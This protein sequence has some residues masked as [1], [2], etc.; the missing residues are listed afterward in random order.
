[1]KSILYDRWGGP[2]VLR[3]G[4]VAEP[5]AGP[6]ELVVRVR[7][8][9]L[10]PLD[11]K[12]RT[13]KM[14]LL[15]G[16]KFPKRTGFDF[17]GIVESCGSRVTGT[18]PGDEVFG[19]TNPF[20][21]D[22]GTFAERCVVRAALAAPKPAGLSFAEAATLPCAGLSALQS[23]QHCRVGPG[24]HV[25]LIGAAGGLGIFALPLAKQLGAHVTAVCS[26]PAIELVRR[27]GADVVLD[28]GRQDPLAPGPAYDAV[29]DLAAAHSFTA[30][31]HLL[32]PRGTYL[33]TLPGPGTLWSQAWTALFSSRKAR[34]L[35]LKPSADAFAK[36]AAALTAPGFGRPGPIRVFP[37]ELPA[38][39]EM[40][41][42][43]EEGHV[44]GKLVV[45]LPDV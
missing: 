32:T 12:I 22:R 3:L 16:R 10:N 20:A 45:A 24:S 39:R 8:A 37:F 6:D 35:M 25:L 4:D 28:R 43:S 1:M 41:R 33:N 31:R 15:A 19:Q 5:V 9:S 29:L 7:A 17:A 40:H 26:E 42:L 18:R 38:V 2:E 34:V 27:L 23:L 36:L 44:Q 14:S 30:C 13:G 11:W 21:A